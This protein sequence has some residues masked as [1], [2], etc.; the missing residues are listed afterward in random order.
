MSHHSRAVGVSGL[1]R[2]KNEAQFLSLSIDSCIEALDELIIVYQKSEDSTEAIIKQKEAQYPDKIKSYF[3][4]HDIKSHH[5]SEAEFDRVSK[6]PLG[7]PELLASY[8][9]LALKKSNYRYAMKIDADQIYETTLLK[10]ICDEYRATDTV[11]ITVLEQ[12]SGFVFSVLSNVNSI[13]NRLFNNFWTFPCLSKRLFINYTNYTLKKIHNDKNPINLCGYNIYAKDNNL[14]LCLG[15]YEKGFFPPFNGV[16]D[17]I[18]FPVSDK[19]YYLPAPMKSKHTKYGNCVIEKFSYDQYLKS[20]FGWKRMLLQSGYIWYHVAPLKT[21]ED[22]YSELLISINHDI[23]Y[24][25]LTNSLKQLLFNGSRYW[26]K[27]FWKYKGFIRND[28]I[29]KKILNINNLKKENE[30]TIETNNFK[31]SQILNS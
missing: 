30:S 10:R 14:Y 1:M 2:V 4:N 24:S 16:Y 31:T 20:R 27:H 9:N 19:T 11:H 7:S 29:L 25:I 13:I 5:L 8:Y 18:I 28:Y 22:V 15:N 6:L 12:F 23:P 17:H 21:K 26:F 3:Y